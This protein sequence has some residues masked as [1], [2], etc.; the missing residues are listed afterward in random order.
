MM[1]SAESDFQRQ[2]HTSFSFAI[3]DSTDTLCCRK[4]YEITRTLIFSLNLLHQAVKIRTTVFFGIH[5]KCKKW[6]LH[7]LLRMVRFQ[8]RFPRPS[9]TLIGSTVSAVG[10][11]TECSVELPNEENVFAT[12]NMSMKSY[13]L[14]YGGRVYTVWKHQPVRCITKTELGETV[15]VIKP[16]TKFQDSAV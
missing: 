5:T 12:S 8:N 14:S 1:P 10:I 2:N 6:A 4:R 13:F 3:K 9:M 7:H 15:F 11:Q 16:L